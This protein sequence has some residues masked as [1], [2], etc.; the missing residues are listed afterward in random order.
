MT[1]F[2][3][4]RGTAIQS[5][6][7]DPSNPEEGQIWYNNTIG[8]LKGYRTVPDTWAAGGNLGSGRYG[9]SGFGTQTAAVACGGYNASG[10]PVASILTEKYDGTTWSPSGNLSS[11]R[12]DGAA[13]GTQTAGLFSGGY[14][15]G[16]RPIATEKFDGSAWT[17]ST[18]LPGIRQGGAGAGTQT[19]SLVFGGFGAA[20]PTD[21]LSS[22]LKFDGTTWTSTGSLNTGRPQLS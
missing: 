6:S 4:I 16:S 11:G 2:K 19:A 9:L 3:E 12:I 14:F 20:N 8:V 13:L 1:T 7:S 18:N 10:Y 17:N 21:V 15:A 5:V 22:A